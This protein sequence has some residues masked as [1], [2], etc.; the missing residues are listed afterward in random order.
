[1][2]VVLKSITHTHADAKAVFRDPT[3][4]AKNESVVFVKCIEDGFWAHKYWLICFHIFYHVLVLR[5]YQPL[6]N[7]H[8]L[9]SG[10]EIRR[11]L[12]WFLV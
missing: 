4:T 12:S 11:L 1:M 3:G 2:A 5:P 10:S 7:T 8:T 9:F 6:S